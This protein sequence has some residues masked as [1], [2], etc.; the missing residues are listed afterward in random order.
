VTPIVG[1]GRLFLFMEPTS[2]KGHDLDQRGMYAL[3]C[4]MADAN[5]TGGEFYLRGHGQH[6]DTPQARAVATQA[7]SYTPHE[8]Y[9]LFELRVAEARGKSYGGVAIPEPTSWH[10]TGSARRW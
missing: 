9:V 8:R 6:D 3:H 1:G 2:P 7:A 4:N 10:A 5:G